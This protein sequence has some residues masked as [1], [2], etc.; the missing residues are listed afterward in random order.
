MKRIVCFHSDVDFR[1]A[2]HLVVVAIEKVEERG[3]RAVR[4]VRAVRAVSEP[5]HVVHVPKSEIRMTE[6]MPSRP[7]SGSAEHGANTSQANPH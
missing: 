5:C 4:T 6:N 2:T 1:M 3:L 7:R